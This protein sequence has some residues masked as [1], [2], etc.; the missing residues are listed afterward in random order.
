M[1]ASWNEMRRWARANL[2]KR[3]ARGSCWH[4]SLGE[5]MTK[6]EL[7]RNPAGSCGRGVEWRSP[8]RGACVNERTFPQGSHGQ[9][10][11]GCARGGRFE[12]AVALS[13]R[14]NWTS[15]SCHHTP[16][17]TLHTKDTITPRAKEAPHHA[18]PQDTR[19]LIISISINRDYLSCS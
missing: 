16:G 2:R 18:Q 7:S 5:L 10:V 6:D 1:T 19:Q 12:R 9:T 4:D 8:T 11:R 13:T 14:G 15:G 3:P 17:S